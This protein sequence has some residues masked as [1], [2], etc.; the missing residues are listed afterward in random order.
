MVSGARF[1][2]MLAEEDPLLLTLDQDRWA[3]GL[4]Y[5]PNP[6][7]LIKLEYSLDD[8]QTIAQSPLDDG[9]EQRDFLGA[10]V[11]TKF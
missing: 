3:A 2:A 4:G 1:R 6:R 10:L 5:W 8:F 11:A 9:A 7:T